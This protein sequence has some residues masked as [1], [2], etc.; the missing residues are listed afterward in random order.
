MARAP[1]AADR[2]YASG[3]RP[4]E[5]DTANARCGH[6]GCVPAAPG[7]RYDDTCARS[8]LLPRPVLARDP[9]IEIGG[10]DAAL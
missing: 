5:P 8:A 7:L 2:V 4:G 3:P 10:H 9:P 1:G 6:K